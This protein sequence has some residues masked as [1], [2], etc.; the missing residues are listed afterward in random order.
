M[1]GRLIY[2]HDRITAEPTDELHPAL[3]DYL[4][5]DS[6]TD[7][8]FTKSCLPLVSRQWQFHEKA[9]IY[10]SVKVLHVGRNSS[11]HVATGR[12]TFDYCAEV[13]LMYDL[14]EGGTI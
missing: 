12:K 6:Q 13:A 8:Q 11:T 14:M 4:N 7:E 1:L 3:R 10:E 2:G 5:D 9:G